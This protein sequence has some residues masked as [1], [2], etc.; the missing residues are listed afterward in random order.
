[1]TVLSGIKESFGENSLLYLDRLTHEWA[2]VVD[3]VSLIGNIRAFVTE[4]IA[5]LG[6]L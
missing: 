5:L 6:M 2:G 4:T 3:D 1:M